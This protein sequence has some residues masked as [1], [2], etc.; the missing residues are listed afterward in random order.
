PSRADAT[1]LSSNI[2]ILTMATS[3]SAHPPEVPALEAPSPTT[4]ARRGAMAVL[5]QA[6]AEE[7]EL[8]LRAVIDPVDYVELRAPETGLVMLRGRIGGDGAAFNL[9]E[10]TVTRARS[11]SRQARWASPTSSGAIRTR[12]ACPPSA[13]R[14]G[15]AKGIATPWSGACSRPY[16]RGSMPSVTAGVG[17]PRPRASISSPWCAARIEPMPAAAFPAPVLAS[18]AAF[19]ALMDAL[20]RPGTIRPLTPAAAAPSPLS[21]TAASVALTALDYETPVWL[22]APLAQ[23]PQVADCARVTP[24]PREAAFA[25]IADPVHAP[26]FDG[27]SLGTPEYPDRSATLVLQVQGFG[28]G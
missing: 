28:S 20:A 3:P 27:F 25:F 21:A 9:G 19:R 10:A 11:K 26:A 13:T 4:A 12:R 17:K 5:A 18:Q 8:G 2:D 23:S 22:D 16:A 6:R 7:I 1:K 14:F 15:K 24:D